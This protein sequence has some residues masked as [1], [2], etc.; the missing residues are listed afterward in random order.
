MVQSVDGAIT[1]I[2]DEAIIFKIQLPNY[3]VPGPIAF[4]SNAG[5]LIIA[6]SN[7]E[8]ESYNYLSMKVFT[9]NDLQG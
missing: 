9:N 6:N 2:N 8:I 4:S 7:L 5:L 3:F 1:V